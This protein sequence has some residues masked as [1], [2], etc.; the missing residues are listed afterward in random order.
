MNTIPKKV[1]IVSRYL[2]DQGPGRYAA[3]LINELKKYYQLTILTT[4]YDKKYLDDEK[5]KLYFLPSIKLL[6]NPFISIWCSIKFFKLA[7][8]SDI[9]FYLAETPYILLFSWFNYFQKKIF[10]LF[11]GT[12][13][14]SYLD[15]KKYFWFLKKIYKRAN[16]IFCVSSFTKNQVLK[17]LSLKN[18]EVIPNG[19]DFDKFQALP[20]NPKQY[21]TNDEK[22]IIGVGA[23]KNRKGFHV[24]IPAIAKVA[25]KID[26]KYYIVGDKSDTTY[27]NHLEKQIKDSGL[28]HKIILLGRV[29]DSELLSLY[30]QADLFLLTPVVI[31]KN[32]FEGFGLVYLEAGAAG[33][34]VIGTYGCGAEEA[35]VNEK[36]GILVPQNNITA[37]AEAVSR[38]L[39]DSDLSRRMGEANKIFA[40][41]SSWSNVAQKYSSFLSDN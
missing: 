18:L 26:L 40:K 28:E 17:R 3:D 13:A 31:Q 23:L 2:I 35:I 5:I 14:V 33:K 11:H 6:K 30:H 10:F 34:P 8:D 1:L 19:V 9:I 20:T 15:N 27:V 12:F 16:K 41:N 36:T 4:E 37:T 39:L 25:E 38:L 29:E 24:S 32:Q 22:I 7:K 21:K